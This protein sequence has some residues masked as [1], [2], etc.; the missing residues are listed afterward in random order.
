MSFKAPW[1]RLS[2]FFMVCTLMTSCVES[3]PT[4][5]MKASTLIA[6]LDGMQAGAL[7]P[8]EY[9]NLMETFEH[10]EAIVHVKKNLQDADSFYLLAFQKGGILK[11]A[12]RKEEQRKADEERKRVAEEIVQKTEE[13]LLQ[14]ARE[15][16]ERLHQQEKLQAEE[17]SRYQKKNDHTSY[18]KSSNNT[19]R[20]TSYTVRR[21]E[22]L[23]QIAA[24]A[25]IYNDASLW[26]L[27]YRA[28]RDQIRDP[29]RLWPGQILTIPRT[30][31]YKK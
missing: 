17:E 21:G 23:P 14:Q 31:I 9:H 25:E 30:A 27:I 26:P 3:A 22:T 29:K 20:Q 13:A 16:E 24:R 19:Q 15:A 7:F 8:V 1:G 4:W 10:G 11:S 18:V 5:R 2:I 6:E 12:I 28:N